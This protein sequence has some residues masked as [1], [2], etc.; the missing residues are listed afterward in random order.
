MLAFWRWH[1]AEEL[2]HKAVAFDLFERLAGGYVLRVASA[3]AAL[4]FSMAWVLPWYP[5]WVLPAT[6]A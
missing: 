6:A 3:L 5:L 2:E 1:A 4:V